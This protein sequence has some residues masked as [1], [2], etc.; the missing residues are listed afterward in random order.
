MMQVGMM[1][2]DDSKRSLEE[3]VER[4][5]T[6]YHEKYGRVPNFCCVNPHMLAEPQLID[7]IEVLPVG[8]ILPHHLWIGVQQK[9][10]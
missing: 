8:N 9:A 10:H 1:W 6:Y 4:A 7:K 5:A 2:L 3:K